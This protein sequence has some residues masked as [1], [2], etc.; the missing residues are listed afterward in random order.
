MLRDVDKRRS[1]QVNPTMNDA[2]EA[3][4]EARSVCRKTSLP[5]LACID[6]D[7]FCEGCGY[8]LRTLP[9]SLDPRTGIPVVRCPECGRFQPANSASTALRP[10]L[11]RATSVLLVTWILAIIAAFIHLGLFEGAVSYATLEELTRPGGSTSQQLTNNTTT[12]VWNRGI[13]PLEVKTDFAAYRLFVTVVLAGSFAI[14]LVCGAM[15]VVVFPHWRRAAGTALVLVMPLAVGA[16]V[17]AIWGDEAPHLFN[18]GL[19]YVAAHAGMQMLGGLV[20]IMLGRPLARLAIRV[21]LPPSVRPRLAFL[22]L[23]DNKPMPRP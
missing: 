11:N 10:W 9:V 21:V 15:A 14:A 17:A 8:N 19:S 18:W 13:G 22:W 7:R 2:I 16:I 12:I 6:L 4:A 20:G 3:S 23:V 5:P 1:L